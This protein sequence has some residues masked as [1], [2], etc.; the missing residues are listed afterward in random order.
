MNKIIFFATFFL[1]SAP[2]FSQQVTHSQL[3]A[4]ENYLKKSK[5]QKTVGWILLGGGATMI[6]A[7]LLIMNNKVNE[8]PLG[9][10]VSDEASASVIL[11]LGGI[12]SAL[13]SIPFF[14]A[15]GKNKRRAAA[16]SFKMEKANI[17]NQWAFSNNPYPAL[18]IR[19]RL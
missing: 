8:D 15:S 11:G 4:H 9:V 7:S 2:S 16:V 13:A 19:V 14:I 5:T 10:L 1:L 17:V 6:T 12:A 18:S 3:P